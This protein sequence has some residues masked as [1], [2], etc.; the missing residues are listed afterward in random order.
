MGKAT[1]TTEKVRKSTPKTVP[2]KLAN[3]PSNMDVTIDL[4]RASFRRAKHDLDSNSTDIPSMCTPTRTTR[5]MAR[6]VPG[7]M[8]PPIP[9][10]V[11]P[12]KR[13]T[14]ATTKTSAKKSLAKTSLAKESDTASDGEFVRPRAPKMKINDVTI[15]NDSMIDES[16]ASTVKPKRQ[17]V[18]SRKASNVPEKQAAVSSEDDL[19][20]VGMLGQSPSAKKAGKFVRSRKSHETTNGIESNDEEN[21]PSVSMLGRN[22]SAKKSGKF[23]RKRKSHEKSNVVEST[24]DE[25]VLSVSKLAEKTSPGR[26]ARSP[27]WLEENPIES[28]QDA[29]VLNN[30]K[31]SARK[32]RKSFVIEKP[33]IESDV[34]GPNGDNNEHNTSANGKAAIESDENGTNGDNN[35]HGKGALATNSTTDNGNGKI[36][37]PNESVNLNLAA[38]ASKSTRRS[39]Q[40]VKDQTES[41]DDAMPSTS[42]SGT[43]LKSARKSTKPKTELATEL[44]PVKRTVKF[45]S[46]IIIEIPKSDLD[47]SFNNESVESSENK[48]AEVQ[49]HDE[50]P[51]QNGD[52]KPL[53]KKTRVS[54]IDLT[55][56]PVNSNRTL[57]E[58][59]SPKPSTSENASGTMNRTFTEEND[60]IKTVLEKTFSPL[61]STS[62]NV[63]AYSTPMLVLDAPS[64]PMSTKK[65]SPQLKR[66]KGTPIRKPGTPMRKPTNNLNTPGKLSSAK[67]VKMAEAAKELYNSSAKKQH[68]KV[69]QVAVNSPTVFRFGEAEN[70]ARDFRFSLLAPGLNPNNPQNNSMYSSHYSHTHTSYAYKSINLNQ[71][72]CF[73][74]IYRQIDGKTDAKFQEYSWSTFQKSRINR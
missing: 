10:F 47:A 38:S 14:I 64:K 70:V 21:L 65:K 53:V 58:T 37:T 36:D 57:N 11:T 42:F 6:P 15:A 22:S 2:K 4:K 20:S 29:N 46:P 7:D 74:F 19:P 40:K 13:N 34:N 71:I 52:V 3:T 39:K 5:S 51:S 32:S 31:S 68:L 41:S 73:H 59:F 24:D 54:V 1:P 72:P 26:Y 9:S 48:G 67:K 17:S 49:H 35:E 69:P 27:Q 16:P 12:S 61:P 43:Q 60:G 62:S 45:T 25:S 56:S 23:A 8:P 63:I 66:L 30:S 44:S 50:Q 33:A 18:K 28:K 55:D